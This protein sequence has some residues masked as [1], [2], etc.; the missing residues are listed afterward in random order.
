MEAR[1]RVVHTDL[2]M[3]DRETSTK[4]KLFLYLVESQRQKNY[5]KMAFEEPKHERLWMGSKSTVI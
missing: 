1:S 4:V 5:S 3:S 2:A